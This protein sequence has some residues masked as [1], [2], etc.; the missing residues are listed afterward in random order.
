LIQES[1]K[2]F[3]RLRWITLGVLVG[4]SI[5]VALVVLVAAIT[6]NHDLDADDAA[7]VAAQWAAEHRMTDKTA[8]VKSCEMDAGGFRFVCHV[9]FESTGRRF[10]LFIR[11]IAPHGNYE[12]V[13]TQVRRGVHPIPDFP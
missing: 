10:T 13:V 12:L 6:A 1:K 5:T 7:K 4:V 11:K 2:R 8:D 9:R 3:Q